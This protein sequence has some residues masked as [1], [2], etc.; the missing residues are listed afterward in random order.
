MVSR[1]LGAAIILAPFT[2]VDAHAWHVGM[3]IAVA[4]C[5]D[6]ICRPRRTVKPGVEE[7]DALTIDTV[8]FVCKLT[9]WPDAAADVWD[10]NLSIERLTS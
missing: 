5:A 4:S 7:Y 10:W 6:L 8:L 9:R 3:V 2:S 1:R